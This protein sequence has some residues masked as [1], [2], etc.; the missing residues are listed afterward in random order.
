M[1]DR[2]KHRK[3]KG[4]SRS[5]REVLF[6]IITSRSEVYNGLQKSINFD[7]KSKRINRRE[8]KKKG[9]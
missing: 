4:E 9:D 8:R 1:T 6:R 2:N 5:E 3:S 7:I